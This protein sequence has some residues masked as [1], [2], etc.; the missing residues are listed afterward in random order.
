M[1][2]TLHSKILYLFIYG[3]FSL[4]GII[5]TILLYHAISKKEHDLFIAFLIVLSILIGLMLLF[6]FK[7]Q[8]VYIID[9]DV[10]IKGLFN[11]IQDH[12]SSSNFVIDD[13]KSGFLSMG[14][15]RVTLKNTVNKKTYRFLITNFSANTIQKDLTN[16]K[17]NN[18]LPRWRS[19]PDNTV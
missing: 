8:R 7:I 11:G 1:K 9:S 2:K 15:F 10:T 3:Y 19:L 18:P 12:D 17:N 16:S 14:V 13:I 4:F 5:G 6:Q